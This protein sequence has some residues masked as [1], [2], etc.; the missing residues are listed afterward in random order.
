[1]PEG[2][3]EEVFDASQEG[4]DAKDVEE[5]RMECDTTYYKVPR[6]LIEVQRRST[7]SLSGIG[8]KSYASDSNKETGLSER[9]Q[10]SL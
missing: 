8:L 10:R 7:G 9:R 4:D 3:E 6:A 5:E 1:M 2:A